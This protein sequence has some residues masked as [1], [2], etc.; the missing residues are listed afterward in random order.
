MMRLGIWLIAFTVL[1]GCTGRAV[2]P[3]SGP[4]APTSPQVTPPQST[5]QPPVT[6][7][8]PSSPAVTVAPGPVYTSDCVGEDLYPMIEA[9]GNFERRWPRAIN[10]IC[11]RAID[12]EPLAL[13]IRLRAESAEAAQAAIRITGG[14]LSQPPH[15]PKEPYNG[16]WNLIYWLEEGKPGDQIEVSIHQSDRE[17]PLVARMTRRAGPA[18]VLSRQSAAGDWVPVNSGDLIPKGE[19]RLRVQVSDGPGPE[20]LIRQIF[21]P[22]S[23]WPRDLQADSVQAVGQDTLELL[24]S[25]PP[26]FVELQFTEFYDKEGVGLSPR[27]V[28]FYIADPPALVAVDPKTGVEQRIGTAPVEVLE[29]VV[30]ADGAWAALVAQTRDPGD[31]GWTVW[32]ANLK[33]GQLKPTGLRL[34]WYGR[35][36]FDQRGRLMIPAQKTTTVIEPETGASQQITGADLWYGLSPDNRYL[37]GHVGGYFG[38]NATGAGSPPPKVEALVIHDLSTGEQ[39]RFPWEGVAFHY[40]LVWLKD[41]R[42]LQAVTPDYGMDFRK[43]DEGRKF[44]TVDLTTGARTP[45]LQ[46]PD[47]SRPPFSKGPR[48]SGRDRLVL[49]SL[50]DGRTLMIHWEMVSH[51][52]HW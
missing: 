47:F 19:L 29:G 21:G 17:R 25:N 10:S 15:V 48:L 13:T 11:E 3:T 44:F 43:M 14:H 39:R 27:S 26:G 45:Y 28:F 41:G 40:S 18:P 30:R 9:R 6:S 34:G 1:V 32:L 51:L 46:R 16:V 38:V 31:W 2:P 5:P 52:R 22:W 42:L 12:L 20:R 37:A 23:T 50:P 24:F 4:S 36:T 8:S 49:G 7:P 33:T 35:L